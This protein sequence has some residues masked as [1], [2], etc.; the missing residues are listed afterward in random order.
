MEEKKEYN[1]DKIEKEPGVKRSLDWCKRYA[2]LDAAIEKV[3]EK[4]LREFVEK[5]TKDLFE[6]HGN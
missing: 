3:P 5:R 6:K 4:D 2:A 1:S